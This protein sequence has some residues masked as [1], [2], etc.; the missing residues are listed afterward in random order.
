MNLLIDGYNLMYSAG[1]LPRGIGPGTLER[2]RR[3]LINLLLRHLPAEQVARTVLVFDAKDAPPDVPSEQQV[4][5]LRV[6]FARDHAE[7]DDLIEQLIRQESAPRRLLVVTSDQRLRTAARR[8]RARA[9]KSEDWLDQLERDAA[10]RRPTGPAQ[11]APPPP[12]RKEQ[13]LSDEETA[14]WLQ[15]FGLEPPPGGSSSF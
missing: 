8:R 7:A 5:G 4:G 13:T 6:L 9:V 10:A 1:L 3:A 2:A 14:A 15:E 12:P 11:P